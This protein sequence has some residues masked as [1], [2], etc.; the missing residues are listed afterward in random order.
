RDIPLFREELG[1]IVLVEVSGRDADDLQALTRVLIVQFLE[2]GNFHLARP[3]PCRPEIDDQRPPFVARQRNFVALEIGQR[4]SRRNLS[5]EI[6]EVGRV[7]RHRHGIGGIEISVRRSAIG[8]QRHLHRLLPRLL[9][10][11]AMHKI[12][13]ARRNHQR[14]S[15]HHRRQYKYV[16]SQT[17]RTSYPHSTSGTALLA[18][19]RSRPLRSGSIRCFRTR[20]QGLVSEPCFQVCPTFAVRPNWSASKP[21]PCSRSPRA[22]TAPWLP[23]STAPLLVS[24]IAVRLAAASSS[25][26]W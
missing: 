4:K 7:A 15:R 5:I 23:T 14:Q 10:S 18:D 25:P 20:F 13:D 1:R 3:A 12:D 8:H 11:P 16:A 9:H 21:M 6:G 26:A 19:R 22:S 2:P 17:R 24:S